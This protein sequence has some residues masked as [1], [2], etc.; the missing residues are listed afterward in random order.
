MTSAHEPTADG[1]QVPLA[2]LARVWA[3][4]SVA[5]MST[6]VL[7]M[8][9]IS[10]SSIGVF[11]AGG[12]DPALLWGTP[13][14]IRGDE[15]MNRTPTLVNQVINDLPPFAP[16]GVGGHNLTVLGDQPT[17]NWPIAFRP[18]NLP[19]LWLSPEGALAW[20]WWSLTAIAI[21][22]VYALVLLLTRRVWVAT[23]ISL[24]VGLSPHMEWW[25]LD[26]ALAAVG[27]TSGAAAAYL[28]ALRARRPL[29]AAAAVIASAY[30]VTAAVFTFYP[31]WLVPAFLV[32]TAVAAATAVAW[33][34]DG[35]VST[36]RVLTCTAVV[37]VIVGGFLAWFVLD[38]GSV[39][40]AI[41]NTSYPGR[42]RTEGGGGSIAQVLSAPFS[43]VIG[44][45]PWPSTVGMNES[46]IAAPFLLLLPAMALVPGLLRSSQPRDVRYGALALLASSIALLAW[47]V[48]PVPAWAGRLLLLDQVPGFR[49]ILGVGLAGALL[50]ALG[51]A[52]APAVTRSWVVAVVVGVAF[53][54]QLEGGRLI[55]TLNP[56]LPWSALIAAAAVWAV[57]AGVLVSRRPRLVVTAAV[58]A[59][60][61]TIATVNPLY[62][63]LGALRDSSVVDAVSSADP[64][65]S[66]LWA[67]YTDSE[68]TALVVSTGASVISAVN[69]Y[70]NA[71]GWSE[72]LGRSE[73]ARTKGIWN[74]YSNQL[75]NNGDENPVVQLIQADAVNVSVS[76]CSPRL[77][78]VGVTHVVWPLSTPPEPCMELLARATH[79]GREYGF[80]SLDGG[81]SP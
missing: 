34:R 76:P 33:W 61:A 15:W 31:P 6:A 74:R 7:S 78:D 25:H 58:A 55:R 16:L 63:G 17:A 39:L 53:L 29:A 64:A 4:P 67:T 48:L 13:R 40:S 71:D 81:D 42:R 52:F 12:S 28:A 21:L 18:D 11:A 80:F 36:A 19:A 14:P 2:R 35:T 70:P 8:A 77:A 62:R 22:G 30:C 66:A 37:A 57:L 24:L 26:I 59:G 56:G 50:L 3:L 27:F 47:T 5:L 75:W 72:L 46:E 68:I 41:A 45:H 44:A 54:L 49:S 38:F 51:L 9:H 20:S 69:W 43:P 23:A 65:R 79:R 73:A 1:E 32:V 10:G 60:L